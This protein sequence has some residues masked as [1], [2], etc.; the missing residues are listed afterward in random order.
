[1]A[2]YLHI[3]KS[4]KSWQQITRNHQKDKKIERLAFSRYLTPPF[5]QAPATS[6]SLPANPQ[7]PRCAKKSAREA[8]STSSPG[9]ITREFTN[10][11]HRHIQ[12]ESLQSPFTSFLLNVAQKP[13]EIFTNK[14][15]KEENRKG[16]SFRTRYL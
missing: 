10:P 4:H 13:S 16:E 11:F 12:G 14:K 7:P 1:M 15:K 5:T 2:R 3:W 6:D 9:S 8:S